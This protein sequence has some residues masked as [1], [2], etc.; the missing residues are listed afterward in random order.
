MQLDILRAYYQIGLFLTVLKIRLTFTYE[1]SKC[2]LKVY[3]K[4]SNRSSL[5]T[6]T[7]F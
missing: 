5:K 2:L 1:S 4:V 7:P 3:T 6:L